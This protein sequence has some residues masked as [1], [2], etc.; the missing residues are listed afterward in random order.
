MIEKSKN[1]LY[2][3]VMMTSLWGTGTKY[4]IFL[5]QNVRYK[6]LFFESKVHAK[7]LPTTEVIQKNVIKVTPPSPRIGLK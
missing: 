3:A 6:I 2:L 1:W 5:H 4:K 7:I